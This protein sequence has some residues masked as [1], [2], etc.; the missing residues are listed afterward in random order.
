LFKLAAG[1]PDFDD[2]PDQYCEH[3]GQRTGEDDHTDRI[4]QCRIHGSV[5]LDLGIEARIIA[6]YRLQLGGLTKNKPCKSEICAMRRA[7]A[8]DLAG[9]ACEFSQ[10]D[11]CIGIEFRPNDLASPRTAR[12]TDDIQPNLDE[13]VA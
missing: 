11:L 13:P 1:S 8:Q 5:C 3:K 6:F 12:L 7:M 9:R 4:I 2:S 10:G